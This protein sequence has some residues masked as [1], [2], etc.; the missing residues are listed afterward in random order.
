MRQLRR[1]ILRPALHKPDFYG[2]VKQFFGFCCDHK[3]C[4]K[5]IRQ[6]KQDADMAESVK[7]WIL[8]HDDRWSF[9]I[10]YIGGAI[11]LSIYAGLFWVAM[12]MLLHFI[13]EL[14]SHNMAGTFRPLFHA[15]W[16]I[17]LDIGLF[18]FALVI[19]LYSDAVMAAL[20]LGH[21]ARAA[22]AGRAIKGAQMATRF[23]IIQRSL[24]VV[25]LIIDDLA[26]FCLAVWKGLNKR[27]QGAGA[28]RP[29]PVYQSIEEAREHG[30]GTAPWHDLG[31]G[32]YFSLGFSALC[33][34]L[35]LVSPSLTGMETAEAIEALLLEL[36]P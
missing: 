13:L 1:L 35:I 11:L 32:D 19:V 26:K 10:L 33:L 23:G 20:G 2:I 30:T 5:T 28:Y 15:L 9:I 17:K 29:E 31:K 8:G 12:L 7:E 18:F 14:I 3:I 16:E 6:G 21:A 36:R 4:G 27:K 25:L 34:M 22:H 24:R